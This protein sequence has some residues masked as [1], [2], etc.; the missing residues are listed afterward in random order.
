MR[1]KRGEPRTSCHVS[2]V[3]FCQGGRS[4][5]DIDAVSHSTSIDHVKPRT[6][7]RYKIGPIRPDRQL[8]Y[9][10][11][12]LGRACHI[13]P[14]LDKAG[15]PARGSSVCYI[16]MCVWLPQSVSMASW[17]C[18]TTRWC[19]TCYIVVL[20]L[21]WSTLVVQFMASMSD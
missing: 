17:S 19:C 2:D 8:Q 3:K 16:A 11:E 7:S 9:A 12:T 14:L 21:T 10:A 15:L 20:S 4:H 18:L 13:M 5:I 1:E 6:T